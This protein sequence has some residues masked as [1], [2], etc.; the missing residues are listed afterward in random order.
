MQ[1][2]LAILRDVA[3]ERRWLAPGPLWARTTRRTWHSIDPA[4]RVGTALRVIPVAGCWPDSWD[5]VLI[6]A[7]VVRRGTL[8]VR[9]LNT[10][11]TMTYVLG[12][13][14]NFRRL[15]AF[16]ELQLD[17]PDIGVDWP[18]FLLEE[19]NT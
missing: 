6:D 18:P 13:W 12:V 2:A 19:G 17:L 8:E 15:P 11:W 1:S 5:G 14:V 16:P 4:Y 10:K 3:A 9:L 7:A